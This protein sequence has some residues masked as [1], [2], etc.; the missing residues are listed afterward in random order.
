MTDPRH[1]FSGIPP[2]VYTTRAQRDF[3]RSGRAFLAA[4][5]LGAAIW[6]A[7]LT[8]AFGATITIRQDGATL[9]AYEIASRWTAPET[10][11]MPKS[12]GK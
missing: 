4:V 3:H 11:P 12:R 6:A 7:I 9:C 2:V 5:V 1:P 10:A 8:A